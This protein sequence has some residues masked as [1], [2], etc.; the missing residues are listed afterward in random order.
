M[1]LVE[2]F[3]NMGL[4]SGDKIKNQTTIP[5]WIM[6]NKLFMKSCIRG[7]IDT[8]GSFYRM[9]KKDPKLMRIGFTNYNKKLLEDT[10]NLFIKLGFNPSKIIQNRQFTISRKEEIKRYLND[11]G[12]SNNKHLHRINVIKA[13]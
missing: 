9:S 7:L 1:S 10:R 6:K 2:F 13:L 4:K 3:V 11:I 5:S 12:S 8:D